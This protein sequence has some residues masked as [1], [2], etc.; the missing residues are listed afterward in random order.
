M[1]LRKY[2][3]EQ[4]G[5][6]DLYDDDGETYNYEKGSYTFRKIMVSKVNGKIKGTITPALKGKPDNVGKVTFKA[7]TDL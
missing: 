2:Y 1:I 5:T 6:Y 4:P 7:M 3:S